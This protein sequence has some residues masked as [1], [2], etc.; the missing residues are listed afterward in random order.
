MKRYN[1]ILFDIDGTLAD[2]DQLI[3]DAMNELY[4]LYRDG[5]RTPV[6]RVVYFSGPPIEETLLHEFPNMDQK[7]MHDEFQRAFQ[8]RYETGLKDYPYGKQA[9]IEL[10]NKGYKVGILTNKNH[11]STEYCLKCLGYE[12]L[13]D[14]I[15]GINDADRPKPYPDGLLKAIKIM[16]E[17]NKTT[18]YIGDNSSD[19]AC[20]KAAD[21]DSMI[22]T[23]GPRKLPKELKPTY[24]LDSYKDLL[25]VIEHE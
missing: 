1:L 4:D 15:I 18:L 24:F 22:V 9:V 23:W 12:N 19:D 20:A 6:E 3:I 10:K 5:N 25:E 13:F 17:S 7:L 8:G 2:T 16:G 14:I 11:K 21:V